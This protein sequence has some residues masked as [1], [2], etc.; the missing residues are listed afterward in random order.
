MALIF[1]LEP[2]VRLECGRFDCP[3]M[4]G[5]VDAEPAPMGDVDKPARPLPHGTAVGARLPRPC[6]AATD[7]VA[8]DG[9]QGDGSHNPRLN[10]TRRKRAASRGLRLANAWTVCLWI[11]GISLGF[12]PDVSANPRP[13][14]FPRLPLVM[15]T[16]WL[17]RSLEPAAYL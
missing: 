9:G 15:M 5:Y 14:I 4:S 3:P 2:A 6:T 1:L 8:P 17:G 12:A 7:P 10:E 11:Y 16:S 13:D